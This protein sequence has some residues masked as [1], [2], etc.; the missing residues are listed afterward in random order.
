MLQEVGKQFEEGG[1]RRM[2]FNLPPLV[3]S[4]LKL[5]KYMAK[6]QQKG[7]TVSLTFETVLDWVLQKCHLIV[8]VP[9]PMMALRCLL[10]CGY[11]A[12][13]EAH[14]EDIAYDCFEQ[15]QCSPVLMNDRLRLN[16]FTESDGPPRW[17]TC[18]E[19]SADY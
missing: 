17:A 19:C 4:G 16:R 15:V 8:E 9:R 6:S 5:V 2:K 14:L 11:A 7:E 10:H 1:F 12:S 18:G 13:E 3:F